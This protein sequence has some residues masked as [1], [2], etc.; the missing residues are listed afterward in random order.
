MSTVVQDRH[1]IANAVPFVIMDFGL[2]ASRR[3][4]MTGL[5]FER[6]IAP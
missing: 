6:E 4:G 5:M 1:C 3:P 2:A